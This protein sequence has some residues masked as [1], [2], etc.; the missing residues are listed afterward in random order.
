MPATYTDSFGCQLCDVV[1]L[2]THV[3]QRKQFIR[4]AGPLELSFAPGNS[5]QQLEQDIT[6]STAGAS[7]ADLSVKAVTNGRKGEATL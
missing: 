7:R 3:Y 2:R 5:H 4:G 6:S 1:G